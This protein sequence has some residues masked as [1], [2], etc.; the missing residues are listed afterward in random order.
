MGEDS[1][2][3]K[4]IHRGKVDCYSVQVWKLELI[5]NE[6]IIYKTISKDEYGH[7]HVCTCSKPLFIEEDLK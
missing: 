2:H 1:Q 3:W 6:V 5:K 4:I 7:V